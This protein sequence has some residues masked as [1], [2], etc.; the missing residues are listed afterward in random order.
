VSGQIDIARVLAGMPFFGAY[1]MAV[2]DTTAGALVVE[3]PFDPKFTTPPDLYPA[4]IVGTIGDIAA[5]AS[6]FSVLPSGWA[7]ATLDF[8][9]KMLGPARGDKLIARG[10]VLQNGRTTSVG[11]SEIFAVDQG[12]ETLCGTVL[13]TTRNFELKR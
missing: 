3:M 10:R 1:R 6:C 11:A 12:R 5:V 8:T 9:I 4:S 7:A 13:A 2:V